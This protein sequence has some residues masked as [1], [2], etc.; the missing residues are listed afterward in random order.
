MLHTFYINGKSFSTNFIF[1]RS[2]YSCSVCFFQNNMNIGH[3]RTIW[4]RTWHT[5]DHFATVT[6]NQMH[7]HWCTSVLYCSVLDRRIKSCHQFM[8]I[9]I[10]QMEE[11]L[12]RISIANRSSVKWRFAICIY[13]TNNNE[14]R[15]EKG[16]AR[17]YEWIK[18]AALGAK[19]MNW[20]KNVSCTYVSWHPIGWDARYRSM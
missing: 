7:R 20:P 2:I 12:L 13:D 4:Y 6:K 11:W 8:P 19:W 3:H 1:F 9:F 18:M 10:F 16:L 17:K 14:K 15:E 5:C